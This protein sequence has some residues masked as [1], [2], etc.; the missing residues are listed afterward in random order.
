MDDFIASDN[1]EDEGVGGALYY[2]YYEL[3]D[4]VIGN[5][6]DTG[7]GRFH[8]SD[9]FDNL[10]GGNPVSSPTKSTSSHSAT[11]FDPLTNVILLCG[12]LG[13][14]KTS[15][16]YA[17]AQELGWSV[18]EVNPGM[19]KRAYKDIDRYVGMVGS[20]HIVG[21]GG[22]GSLASSFA[23]VRNGSARTGIGGGGS[24]L[25][26]LFG[27]TKKKEK[28]THGKDAATGIIVDEEDASEDGIPGPSVD[29][30]DNAEKKAP[31]KVQ[32]SL[33]LIEE[34]DVLY[35]SDAGF[36]EGVY[37][38]FAERA[39]QFTNTSVCNCQASSASSRNPSGQ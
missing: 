15:S 21:N 5:K 20:N 22:A 33:V 16:V 34:V 38:H 1:S 6:D 17:V 19:G 39:R 7:E 2:D 24:G 10:G 29:T 14:G 18:F 31:E 8:G 4:D 11:R 13:S 23:N 3:V 12:P 26:P 27:G 32:Q 30:R 25:A 37:L 36:W 9:D 35:Q 28:S